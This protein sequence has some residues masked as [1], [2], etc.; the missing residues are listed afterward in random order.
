MKTVEVLQQNEIDR[1]RDLPSLWTVTVN[2]VTQEMSADRVV[3]L[4]DDEGQKQFAVAGAR[5]VD[6]EQLFSGVQVDISVLERAVSERQIIL[7]TN[8]Q[9]CVAC[10]PVNEGEVIR[11]VLYADRFVDDGAF[12]DDEV[13]HLKSIGLRA[14]KRYKALIETPVE[15]VAPEPVTEKSESLT[16]SSV[17]KIGEAV[18]SQT[19]QQPPST[20]P[21][22]T[23]SV[24][25]D[26]ALSGSK[27]P[28][29]Q[30]GSSGRRPLNPV[31]NRNRP[32]GHNR[33]VA[34]RY[35]LGQTLLTCRFSTLIK[36]LDLKHGEPLVLR[37]LELQYDSQ[38]AE[39]RSVGVSAKISKFRE[40]RNQLMRE[41]RFLARLQHPSLPRVYE[42]IEDQGQVYLVLEDMAGQTLE[43][44]ENSSGE[45]L[46]PFM[47]TRYFEQLLDA[48]EYLHHQQPPII[49][50][51]LRP[52]GILV[53]QY[54]TLKLA[55]FG[56]AKLWEGPTDTNQTA[57]RSQGSPF[58][59]P[60]EQ[61]MGEPSS[62]ANDFYALGSVLFYLAT[63]QLPPK[64]L[65]RFSGTSE[66]PSLAKLRPDLHPVFQTLVEGLTQIQVEKRLVD[67]QLIRKLIGQAHTAPAQACE[68]DSAL[69][70][71]PILS[72]LSPSSKPEKLPQQDLPIDASEKTSTLAKLA[73]KF[74][75]WN[76][77]L[78]SGSSESDSGA[79]A[80]QTPP[81][82]SAPLP[83]ASEPPPEEF[84]RPA[85]D[86]QPPSA[87]E[88]VPLQTQVEASTPPH[89][90]QADEERQPENL[91]ETIPG[92]NHT[93]EETFQDHQNDQCQSLADEGTLTIER[94]GPA[95][96]LGLQALIEMLE[97]GTQTL[98]LIPE[99]K[100][101]LCVVQPDQQTS[102]LMQYRTNLAELDSIELP[103]H[104]AHY[105]S[106]RLPTALGETIF[107]QPAQKSQAAHP[108]DL[109][110]PPLLSSLADFQEGLILVC[111][112]R[113]R[114]ATSRYHW[115]LHQFLLH[116]RSCLQWPSD[117]HAP[118]DPH[119]GLTLVK[120]QPC[121]QADVLGVPHLSLMDFELC[122]SALDGQTVLVPLCASSPQEALWV[123]GLGRGEL[124][125][126]YLAKSCQ[127]LVLDLEL[128]RLCEECRQSE[129]PLSQLV[130]LAQEQG[131][132]QVSQVFEAGRCRDCRTVRPQPL[133]L[134]WVFPR[135]QLGWPHCNASATVQESGWMEPIWA[136]VQ[137]GNVSQATLMDL[138]QW[139]PQ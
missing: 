29:T 34:G 127:F 14:L 95:P 25:P 5:R 112:N 62:P 131:W 74:R 49:H 38:Q 24:G 93:P 105:A 33:L 75:S 37:R 4:L 30:S 10:Y 100:G 22:Q 130:Q 90:A 17:S 51:D 60:P 40:A 52:N 68:P 135:Q 42:V 45:P 82:A 83:T 115:L 125:C 19:V 126:H 66:M 103:Q 120:N 31:L 2:L 111:S 44:P 92:D 77:L 55:E 76:F 108:S 86:Q 56:L 59:S 123:L 106:E 12:E 67:Y 124:E 98:Q 136:Q 3:V 73:Q 94:D 139:R 70:S 128:P 101:T 129:S 102:Y 110:L 13:S 63:R 69:A 28:V 121:P 32:S 81:S 109:G 39:H 16:S 7:H 8:Q 35:Q 118:T 57:F 104:L 89:P 23:V 36:A 72:T 138:L 133:H 47:L 6:A 58:Y 114:L 107:I 46:D 97:Q 61:L 79:L 71:S 26:S 11:L 99:K 132:E 134:N 137:Q 1:A 84:P 87:L 65:E 18:T 116:G 117:R 64:T 113:P 9:R 50:R 91:S 53:G 96:E 88:E 43:H 41:G 80:Q 20:T 48:L 21:S 78:G 15:E 54:G 27:S 119:L 122:S 85:V